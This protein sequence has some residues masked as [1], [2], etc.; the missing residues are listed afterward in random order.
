MKSHSLLP[1]L[2]ITAV[3]LAFYFLGMAVLVAREWVRWRNEPVEI[4]TVSE[5]T[6][7]GGLEFSGGVFCIAEGRITVPRKM[8]GTW[9]VKSMGTHEWMISKQPD[10]KLRFPK[11]EP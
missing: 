6:K 11:Q 1:C 4:G 2:F 3:V 9:T 5:I 10:T 7:T 8:V